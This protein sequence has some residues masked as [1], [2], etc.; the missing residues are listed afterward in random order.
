MVGLALTLIQLTLIVSAYFL[1]YGDGDGEL[2]RNILVEGITQLLPLSE[3]HKEIR[4]GAFTFLLHFYAGLFYPFFIIFHI[5]LGK[6]NAK[7]RRVKRKEQAEAG[8]IG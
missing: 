7:K 1:Y 2:R 4:E 3:E 6:R 8:S 5:V